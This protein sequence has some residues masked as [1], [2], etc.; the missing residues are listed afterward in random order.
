MKK[1]VKQVIATILSLVLVLGIGYEPTFANETESAI[2]ATNTSIPTAQ[3]ISS[4]QITIGRIA[5]TSSKYYFIYTAPNSGYVSFNLSRSDYSSTESA[6]WCLT[7]YDATMTKLEYKT[8][9]NS[10]YDTQPFM[11]QKGTTY[12]IEVCGSSS[13]TTR[14]DYAIKANFTS[15][16]YVEKEN[17]NSG[18]KATKLVT[19]KKYIGCLNSSNDEDFFKIKADKSGYYKFSLNRYD[20]STTD[21]PTWTMTVYDSSMNKLY[22]LNS[23]FNGDTNNTSGV[24]YVLPK[25]KT[26][27]IKVSNSSSA[28]GHLYSIQTT[29]KKA[30]NIESE[31]N[32]SYTQADKIKISTTYY[33]ALGETST[34]DYFYF[35]A[36]A[37]KKYQVSISLNRDVTYGYKLYVY[38]SSRKLVASSSNTIYKNGKLSFK[39]K[40]G[41]KYYVV[42]KH[43]D[44]GFFG[45]YSVGTLYKLKVVKK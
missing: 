43:A 8:Y 35:K 31:P 33:G 14:I 19:G 5:D 7:V 42:V 12:Y 37:D 26:I 18:T 22:S 44:T 1:H 2:T 10:S 13:S 27:Y 3:D 9:I 15:C 30:S 23:T 32:N 41:K 29:F 40:K 11:V 39:A 34:A 21:T 4:G 16:S 38:D 25:G 6:A 28:V 45:G 17:N 24:Y 20:F 36:T